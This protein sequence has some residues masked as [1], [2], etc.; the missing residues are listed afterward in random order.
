MSDQQVREFYGNSNLYGDSGKK[1]SSHGAKTT[2]LKG[3]RF[4]NSN[5]GSELNSNSGQADL[6]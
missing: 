4:E 3:K 6:N 1:A 5:Q 2:A